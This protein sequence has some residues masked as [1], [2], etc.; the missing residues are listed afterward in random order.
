MLLE[1]RFFPSKL[2][3]FMLAGNRRG[4][5]PNNRRSSSS[6]RVGGGGALVF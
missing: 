3:S 2:C 4:N 5:W 1:M 6:A